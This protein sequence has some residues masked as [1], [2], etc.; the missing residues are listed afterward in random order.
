[1][2][3]VPS[4]Q[5]LDLFYIDFEILTFFSGSLSLQMHFSPRFSN[6][7]IILHNC[8]HRWFP[9]AGATFINV[10]ILGAV[11]VLALC[12]S[13]FCVTFSVVWGVYRMN[14]YA[15]IGQDIL[16]SFLL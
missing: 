4:M 15:W 8:P 6:N 9:T 7:K 14:S 1:M 12:L 3:G 5:V 2:P 13:P 16:V 11:S 10:P